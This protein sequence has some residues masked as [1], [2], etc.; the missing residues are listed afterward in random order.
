M[1]GHRVDLATARIDRSRPRLLHFRWEGLQRLRRRY[2]RLGAPRAWGQDAGAQLQVRTAARHR[3]RR[4]EEPNA[5]VQVETGALTIPNLKATQVELYQGLVAR[6]TTGWPSLAFDLKSLGG[7]F[8][9]FMPAGFYYKTFKAPGMLWPRY[10]QVI[11]HAAGYG[12][13]PLE[14]DPESYDYAHR[15]AEVLV[16]GAGAAGLLAA[17][18]AGRAGLDVILLDEQSEPGGW[19]LSTP[20]AEIGGKSARD[21]ID[22]ILA[23]LQS[24]PNVRILTRT[25]AFALHEM[26]LIQ[27]VE[28]VADHIPPSAA[29]RRQTPPAPAPH[30][31]RA[32][33]A[34]DGCDR[35]PA[36]VRQQ[37]PSGVFYRLGNHDRPI[38][39]AVAVGRRVLILTS[40]DH[41]YQGAANSP[42]RGRSVVLADTRER[43]NPEWES[44]PRRG[45]RREDRLRN[46]RGS[47]AAR[48]R[49]CAL[50]ASRRREERGR[51][52]GPQVECDAV[53]SS[54][55]LSPTVH[56]YCHDGG[57]RCGTTPALR[58]SRL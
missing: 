37:R 32:R 2:A 21:W 52:I 41:A 56:L 4:P 1:R 39:Y 48:G 46:R 30:T 28:Q 33:R 24:L 34:G 15:H 49:R 27:A 22:G 19:L 20:H 3:R 50:G 26:N 35:P 53:A 57:R 25:S 38:R 31:R 11:C 7:R 42:R 9:Q 45:R 17:L 6:R 23:E 14:P 51:W 44:R 13:S 36:R 43:I 58:S 29:G 47:R 8:S 54:G 10:E 55:G 5:L 18:G 12:S 16:I 40:N